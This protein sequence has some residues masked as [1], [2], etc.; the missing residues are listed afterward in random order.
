MHTSDFVRTQLVYYCRVNAAPAAGLIDYAAQF[1]PGLLTGPAA[2]S[3]YTVTMPVNF[4]VPLTRRMITVTPIGA[5][6]TACG[7]DHAGS[8]DNTVIINGWAVAGLAGNTAFSLKI[9]RL[10]LL[11]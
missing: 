9:Y 1:G 11:P 3:I 8:A 5:A 4:T 2:A 7:Y 10:E 6:G